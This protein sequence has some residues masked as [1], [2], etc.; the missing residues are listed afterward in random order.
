MPECVKTSVQL[1]LELQQH[2]ESEA[3]YL[4]SLI[5]IPLPKFMLPNKNKLS[6]CFEALPNV[7]LC[8]VV[9]SVSE[10]FHCP[11][12]SR[13]MPVSVQDC[14]NDCKFRRSRVLVRDLW[15]KHGGLCCWGR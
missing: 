8:V 1:K 6:L 4:D 11:F 7:K 10:G 13:P 2:P 9:R 14:E 15:F 12:V 3:G 5:R